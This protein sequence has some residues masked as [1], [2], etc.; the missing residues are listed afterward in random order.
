MRGVLAWRQGVGGRKNPGR[1][2][3]NKRL[4]VFSLD[5]NWIAADDLFQFIFLHQP[6]RRDLVDDVGQ[7]T[8][9]L[10]TDEAGAQLRQRNRTDVVSSEQLAG[11]PRDDA[12]AI[13][14]ATI[15][16]QHHLVLGRGGHQVA[17]P[18]LQELDL[19][20]LIRIIPKHAVKRGK[21]QRAG[22]AGVVTEGHS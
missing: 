15:Q 20:R 12:F 5:L 11:H 4:F 1:W 18:L 19:Q 6:V 2:G 10:R 21:P 7:F 9:Q 14:A 3:K 17:E 16:P 8:L 22:C 13:S